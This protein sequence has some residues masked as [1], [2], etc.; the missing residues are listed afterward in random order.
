MFSLHSENIL[1]L[2]Y[3]K[4]YSILLLRQFC[5]V[6]LLLV[7]AGSLSAQ[8]KNSSKY[9]KTITGKVTDTKGDPIEGASIQGKGKP[10]G[11]VT[12]ADGMFSLTITDSANVILVF[13]STNYV[14]KEVRI[15]IATT[16]I[17]PR[18]EDDAKALND[19][20]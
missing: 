1:K 8:K 5:L 14:T 12:N 18:L 2:A 17:N 10:Y 3:M 20:V 15:P 7:V 13:S 9:A 6:L 16:V 11:T 4:K 19:V